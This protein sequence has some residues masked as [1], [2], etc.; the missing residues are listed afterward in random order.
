MPLF[1]D[2]STSLVLLKFPLSTA[3]STGRK[4]F[5]TPEEEPLSERQESGGGSLVATVFS[6]SVIKK[7]D[8]SCE[9]KKKTL[10]TGQ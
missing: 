5:L 10:S 7:K 4:W 9:D 6:T 8:R 2:S 1:S 3:P